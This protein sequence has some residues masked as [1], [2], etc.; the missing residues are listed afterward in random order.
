MSRPKEKIDKTQTP[1]PGSYNIQSKTFVSS[2]KGIILLGRHKENLH[3]NE[4]SPGPGSYDVKSNYFD[5]EF[6]KIS[7][8]HGD[9]F[10]NYVGP[11][12]QHGKNGNKEKVGGKSDNSIPGPGHYNVKEGPHGPLF[13]IGGVK[14][15]KK[16]FQGRHESPGPGYYNHNDELDVRM[17]GGRFSSSKRPE[18]RISL[19]PGPGHYNQNADFLKTS[20]AFTLKGKYP[21]KS[22]EISPGPGHY[23]PRI[24]K[25]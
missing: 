12:S 4:T 19:D 24:M 5:S 7:F 2:S 23:D 16:L 3:K 13:S 15:N 25:K 11:S 6:K 10:Q 20:P 21:E 17:K 14:D 22:P 9:R 18:R 8:G 1:G